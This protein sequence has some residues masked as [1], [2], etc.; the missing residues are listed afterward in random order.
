MGKI[1]NRDEYMKTLKQKSIADTNKE[2]T[3]QRFGLFS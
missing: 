2:A 1:E 3:K